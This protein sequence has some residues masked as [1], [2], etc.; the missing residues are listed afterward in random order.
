MQHW[1]SF[2][3]GQS[4]ELAECEKND[5]LLTLSIARANAVTEDIDITVTKDRRILTIFFIVVFILQ[6]S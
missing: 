1:K 5:D 4:N 3:Y 2:T 6:H